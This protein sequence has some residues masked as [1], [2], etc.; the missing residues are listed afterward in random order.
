MCERISG[1]CHTYK[2][3]KVS[4]SRVHVEYSNPDEYGRDRPVVAVYPCFPGN[5]GEQDDENPYVILHALRYL[6]DSDGYDY[7]AFDVLTDCPTLWRTSLPTEEK[8]EWESHAEIV[9]RDGDR[10][11][12]YTTKADPC[13]VCDLK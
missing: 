6:H 12:P 10:S 5:V 13:T 2:V 7:Q 1:M 9:K 8:E 11:R 4:R 3:V